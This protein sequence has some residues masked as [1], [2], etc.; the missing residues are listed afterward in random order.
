MGNTLLRLGTVVN[1]VPASV[2]F[3]FEVALEEYEEFFTDFLTNE[4][5]EYRKYSYYY[6]SP[7]GDPSQVVPYMKSYGL[8]ILVFSDGE[9]EQRVNSGGSCTAIAEPP[10]GALNSTVLEYYFTVSEIDYSVK[11]RFH[12]DAEKDY[13]ES[14]S[15]SK[16]LRFLKRKFIL[17][18]FG[19]AIGRDSRY[20]VSYEVVNVGNEL[21][22]CRA[23]R[24]KS[25]SE[26]NHITVNYIKGN[27][28]ITIGTS[29]EENLEKLRIDIIPYSELVNE[30]E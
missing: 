11:I 10:S 27:F 12:G 20:N 24:F 17:E 3:R 1:A 25:G 8:P 2:R 6:D 5:H 7:L 4:E 18:D 23:E 9:T 26:S 22:P 30:G 14:I 13:Y 28:C 16:K 15:N 21:L 19:R 29:S